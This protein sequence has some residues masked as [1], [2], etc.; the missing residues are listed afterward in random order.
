MSLNE[1]V[2]LLR[3]VPL[4]AKIE[5]ARVAPEG[6]EGRPA[7]AVDHAVTLLTSAV[8]ARP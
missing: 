6:C 2:E 3:S 1:E 8:Q 4:F 7:V 5:P